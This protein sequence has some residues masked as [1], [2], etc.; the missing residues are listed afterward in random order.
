MSVSKKLKNAN[1]KNNVI[2][3]EPDGGKC[4]SKKSS[5]YCIRTSE[6]SECH[7][8]LFCSVF[9]FLCLE[10]SC[11]LCLLLVFFPVLCSLLQKNLHDSLKVLGSLENSSSWDVFFLSEL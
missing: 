2:S 9:S 5:T 1:V 4:C 7:L 11:F 10:K 3:I 6:I 8:V